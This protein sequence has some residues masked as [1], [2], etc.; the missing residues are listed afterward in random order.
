MLGVLFAAVII[1]VALSLQGAR[2]TVSAAT[3]GPIPT[4]GGGQQPPHAP[5][6]RVCR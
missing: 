2:P 6:G 5:C 3:A 1:L 4:F